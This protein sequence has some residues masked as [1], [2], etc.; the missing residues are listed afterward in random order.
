MK[1]KILNRLALLLEHFKSSE[2]VSNDKDY[3]LI[4]QGTISGITY[5]IK[6]IEDF[7]ENPDEEDPNKKYLYAPAK[8]SPISPYL[9]YFLDVN[10]LKPDE[11]F[12]LTDKKGERVFEKSTFEIGC[13]GIFHIRDGFAGIST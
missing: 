5:A 6:S 10:Y 12:Y 11:R 1:E 13:D 8:K 7:F 4:N 2:H 3:T 9:Q